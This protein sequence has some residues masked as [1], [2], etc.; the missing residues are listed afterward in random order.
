MRH[1]GPIRRLPDLTLPRA[2]AI[3]RRRA[4]TPH[5]AGV[6]PPQ[7]VAQAAVEVTEAEVAA[8]LA[9]AAEGAAALMVAD[10]VRLPTLITNI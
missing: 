8:A 5:L 9:E 4:R 3:Q 2:V 1:K 7:A 10:A 6:T